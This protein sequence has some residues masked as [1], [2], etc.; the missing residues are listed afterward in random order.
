L[1]ETVSTTGS[2]AP[3]GAAPP[4]QFAP[5]CQSE[6]TLP[7]QFCA[8][9]APTDAD[10]ATAVANADRETSLSNR[11]VLKFPT[12]CR[13]A[14]PDSSVQDIAGPLA[15]EGGNWRHECAN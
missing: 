8:V 10:I 9:A 3:V 5:S 15:L 6:L 2:T 12:P 13:C 1:G 7:C 4:L 11:D 14:N